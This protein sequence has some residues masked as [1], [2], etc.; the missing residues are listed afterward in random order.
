MKN[1]KSKEERRKE[2][3]QWSKDLKRAQ[4]LID[5]NTKTFVDTFQDI[6]NDHQK[7]QPPS[8]SK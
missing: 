1:P 4:K 2:S 5:Q 7:P 6:M 8:P 3:I